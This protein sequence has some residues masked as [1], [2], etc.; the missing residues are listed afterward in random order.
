MKT[1]FGIATC[2]MMLCVGI[3]VVLSSLNNYEASTTYA[4]VEWP[5]FGDYIVSRPTNREIQVYIAKDLVPYVE[6]TGAHVYMRTYTTGW[7]IFA[8]THYLYYYYTNEYVD[9][10][11]EIRSVGAD[12]DSLVF[13]IKQLEY[14]ARSYIST[15][16]IT[17]CD[18]D[19][20]VLGY[21]RNI[22][23]LYKDSNTI[24]ESKTGF[25]FKIICGEF[26]LNFVDYVNSQESAVYTSQSDALIDT[27]SYFASFVASSERV[28]P[29]YGTIR[30]KYKT[31]A[32]KLMVPSVDS[33]ATG[34]SIDLLHLF[35]SLDGL[36]YLG[37]SQTQYHLQYLLTFIGD[38]HTACYDF[39][40]NDTIVIDFESQVLSPISQT[41]FSID[42]LYA[43]TDAFNIG[44]GYLTMS[45]ESG[46]RC[47]TLSEALSGYYKLCKSDPFYRFRSFIR[48]V[49]HE[50]YIVSNDP[51]VFGQFIAADLFA[52]GLNAF[53]YVTASFSTYHRQHSLNGLF[54]I[55]KTRCYT[56]YAIHMESATSILCHL[57]K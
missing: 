3:G 25:A 19:N 12:I 56:F 18:A 41:S 34:L 27:K 43:D 53:R 26:D 51:Q 24:F 5:G 16:S 11:V 4:R 17:S 29:R 9:E 30:N 55:P 48:N 54:S 21:I 23:V 40:L 22:D 6:E 57:M 15:N 49:A 31:I 52:T 44:R 38:L 1:K 13:M 28:N 46:K 45:D 10:I 35:C 33:P 39:G 32:Q 50:F 8:E 20:L 36:E 7:W 2:F 47:N 14:Y 42:D 37:I